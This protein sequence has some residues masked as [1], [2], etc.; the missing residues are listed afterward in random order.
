MF[1]LEL[2]SLSAKNS[3]AFQKTREIREEAA[4]KMLN[5]FKKKAGLQNTKNIGWVEKKGV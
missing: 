3:V 1:T 4:E 5:Y 2:S